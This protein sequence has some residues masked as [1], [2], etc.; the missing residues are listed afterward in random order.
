MPS[1]SVSSLWSSGW[2]WNVMWISSKWVGCLRYILLS[3]ERWR[4]G[5]NDASCSSLS[6]ARCENF[7]WSLPLSMWVFTIPNIVLILTFSG[8][9]VPLGIT[10]SADFFAWIPLISLL[11]LRFSVLM[12]LFR[13]DISSLRVT[14]RWRAIG[15]R[16]VRVGSSSSLISILSSS[17]LSLSFLP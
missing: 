10:V 7:M 15:V 2:G 4:I 16:G 1:C 13:A 12:A 3:F 8:T 17:Y 6:G 5:T 11:I 14:F 9:N